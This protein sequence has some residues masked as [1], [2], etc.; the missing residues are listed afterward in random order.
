MKFDPLC[1]IPT[2]AVF[3][4]TRMADE[5]DCP[6]IGAGNPFTPI[7]TIQSI[8][9]GNLQKKRKRSPTDA[10]PAT[11]RLPKEPRNPA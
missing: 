9:K 10:T 6:V 11:K 3:M 1:S 8:V 4:D 5:R 7:K 2:K